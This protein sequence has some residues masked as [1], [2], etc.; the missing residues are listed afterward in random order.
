MLRVKRV[1]RLLVSYTL[2]VYLLLVLIYQTVGPGSGELETVLSYENYT[3]ARLSDELFVLSAHHEDRAVQNS[4]CVRI[5]T[6]AK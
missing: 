4:P 1:H 3:W 5:I 2:L 6:I